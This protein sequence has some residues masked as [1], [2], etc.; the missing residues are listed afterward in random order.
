MLFAWRYFKARKSTNAI[1]IIAR[2]SMIAITVITAAFIIILS[3]FNGF[4]ALVKS[5]YSSFY[6]D[7]SIAPASGKNIT[8]SKAQLDQTSKLPNV[9]AYS[10]VVEDKALLQNGE[11]QTVV[12]LKGVDENY[13]QIA[14]VPNKLIRGKFDLGSPDRASLVL[15]SGI[16]NALGLQSDRNLYPITAYLFRRGVNISSVDPYDAFSVE[17]VNTTGT[18]YIQQDIDN[19]YAITNVDF[20]KKMLSMKENEYGAMEIALN[21]PGRIE[22]T[23][24]ALQKIFGS[25][26]QVLTRYEQNRSLFSTM[27][28]E[29]WVMYAVLTMM[30]I[31]AS[32]TLIGSLTMLVLEKQ[33]DIQILKALGANNTRIRSIFLAEGLLLG[34]LGSSLGVVLALIICWAQVKFKL[35]NINGGTFLISYY[36]VRVLASD[37]LLIGV[38]VIFITFLASWLPARKA[39]LQPVELKS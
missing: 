34:I 4:E 18:F 39:S 3:V 23:R 6:S 5:L 37:L 27:V 25:G 26:Y 11:I 35:I 14:K 10:L 7:I 13:D 9:K 12:Q 22:S 19:T 32:F 15:G 16:E 8:I 36:P 24:R 33:K 2:V 31:V 38:T 30:L 29:K 1:N 21:D 28:M 20:M 17:N